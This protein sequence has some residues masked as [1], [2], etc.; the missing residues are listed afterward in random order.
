ME[1]KKQLIT[2][3][4]QNGIKSQEMWDKFFQD[5]EDTPVSEQ[6]DA[7]TTLTEQIREIPIKFQ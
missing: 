2:T 6:I 5:D 3:G 4:I 1:M 7:P